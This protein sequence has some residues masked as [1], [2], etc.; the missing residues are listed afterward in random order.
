MT[1]PIRGDA[2]VLSVSEVNAA[3][4][5]LLREV[6]GPIAIAGEIT[7]WSVASSGHI[8]FA[9]KDL[10]D[11]TINCALWRSQ[12]MNLPAGVP[13]GNGM[14]VVASGRIG[15]YEKSGKFQFYVDR[16]SPQGRGAADEALRKLKEKLQAKGYFAVERKRPLPRYPRRI[17]VVTSKRGAAVRDILK[18]MTA[19]WPGHDIVIADTRVQGEG[20]GREIAAAVETLSRLH[21]AGRLPLD[22]LI[23]GR[24]GGGDEDLA[25]FNTEVVADAIFRCPVPVISAVGHEVDITLSDLVADVRAATPT[26][27]AQMLTEEWR[28]AA[29]ILADAKIRLAEGLARRLRWARERLSGVANRRCFAAPL[30][31][32][33]DLEQRVDELARRVKDAAERHLLRQRDRVRSLA[34]R[35]EALSPLG[36]LHRGYSLTQTESGRIVRDAAALRVGDGLVTRVDRGMIRSV[37]TSVTTVEA[38]NT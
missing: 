5:G 37:V 9:L 4:A 27:A 18:I 21:Q 10:D 28:A 19:N 22:A 1:Q 26:H 17:G 34:G 33:R 25:A 12:A 16:L 32:V 15:L 8:Y 2:H 38:A 23:V 30:D 35:L 24:G 13:F 31:R 29:G 7:G 6:F 14:L 20:A 3:V 36:V 11:T